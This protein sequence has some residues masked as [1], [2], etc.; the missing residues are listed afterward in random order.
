VALTAI[1][2]FHVS[3]NLWWLSADDCLPLLDANNH[4]NNVWRLDET[5]SKCDGSLVSVKNILGC[6]WFYPPLAYIP[7]LVI[8]KVFGVSEDLFSLGTTVWF[9]AFMVGTYVFASHILG[10]GYGL[11]ATLFVSLSPAV[12]TWSRLGYIDVALA[13]VVVW[14]LAFW[15]KSDDFRRPLWTVVFVL[16]AVSSCLTKQA[17]PLF[18]VGP[19]LFSGVRH[20]L[21]DPWLSR[22]PGSPVSR[23]RKAIFNWNTLLLVGLAITGGFLILK[24]MAL[25]SQEFNEKQMDRF[26]EKFARLLSPIAWID[27]VFLLD[28]ALL[29]SVAVMFLVSILYLLVRWTNTRSGAALAALALFQLLVLGIWYLWNDRYFLPA[30]PLYMI[31]LCLALKDLPERWHVRRAVPVVIGVYLLFGFVYIS[32]G[33]PEIIKIQAHLPAQFPPHGHCTPTRFC[34]DWEVLGRRVYPPIRSGWRVKDIYSVICSY[35]QKPTGGAWKVGVV[36]CIPAFKAWQFNTWYRIQ[37]INGKRASPVYFEEVAEGNVERLLD[38]DFLVIASTAKGQPRS[39]A[40]KRTKRDLELLS[41]GQAP[42]GS[43]YV[44]RATFDLQNGW[45]AHLYVR[46]ASIGSL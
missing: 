25:S 35:G 21:L 42:P 26:S 9:V 46:K 29:P 6:T 24:I 32:T 10:R 36:K 18:L 33:H 7:Y 23:F 45:S 17:A 31:V 15:S 44:L 30:I 1:L 27:H 3:F 34:T 43:D 40:S 4:F 41:E 19:A 37:F 13:A 5:L 28:D 8:F 2:A 16:G 20:F 11:W 38:F 22:Q 12:Y 39:N 14:T